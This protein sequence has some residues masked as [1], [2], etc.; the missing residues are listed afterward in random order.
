[1]N[2]QPVFVD[3]RSQNR[4]CVLMRVHL[5]CLAG[6]STPNSALRTLV[7]R[8]C[9]KLRFNHCLRAEKARGL[10]TGL[11]YA[12]VRPGLPLIYGVYCANDA[13]TR[14]FCGECTISSHY[15]REGPCTR[16]YS[17][18]LG[19]ERDADIL[20]QCWRLYPSRARVRPM[21]VESSIGLGRPGW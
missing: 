13:G 7:V 11:R 17:C 8:E 14:R 1:L 2:L 9:I 18:I 6:S 3:P 10:T 16:A 5:C 19:H 12:I 15:S 20:N 21:T 4:Y